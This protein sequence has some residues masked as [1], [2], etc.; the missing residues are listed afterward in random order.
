MAPAQIGTGTPTA[1]TYVDGGTGAW[2]PLPSGGG[3]GDTFGEGVVP[4]FETLAQ[5]EAWEAANPG[6]VALTLESTEPDI[7][8][9]SAGGLAVDMGHTTATLT[10]SG[11]ADDRG[12]A[13][14][15]F[16][17]D[18]GAWSDW[19]NSHVYEATGLAG[20]TAYAFQHR[21]RDAAGNIAEGIATT[22]TTLAAPPAQAG[23]VITSDGF[24]GTGATAGRM[25]DCEHGGT[26]IAWNG[27]IQVADGATDP[28]VTTPSQ[29]VLPIAREDVRADFTVLSKPA[30]S[31][32]MIRLRGSSV[33][34]HVMANTGDIQLNLNGAAINLALLPG[35]AGPV[36]VR[37]EVQGADVRAW[38]WAAGEAMPSA[39]QKTGTTATTGAH[40]LDISQRPGFSITDLVVTAL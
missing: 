24:S 25:T 4:I 38:A 37:V 15:S 8:P 6:R 26:P 11:A 19:Q 18:S 5:A 16:K 14:Y 1:G 13:G 28:A 2:T 34:V 39:P 12:V 22:G 30:T 23:E 35:R 33:S 36:R 7:T 9:P 17:I 3:G 32:G 21:V 20:S 10:V 29:P 31:R 27:T 40:P